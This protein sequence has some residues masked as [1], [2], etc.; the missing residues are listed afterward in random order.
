MQLFHLPAGPLCLCAVLL[1]SSTAG[2]AQSQATPSQI[3]P[4]TLP[5]ELPAEPATDYFPLATPIEAAPNAP[6][7]DFHGKVDYFIK[8]VSSPEPVARI[9]LMSGFKSLGGASRRSY[10]ENFA[11]RY[12]EHLTKR[13]VQFGIG[14]LRGEDPRFHRSGQEGFWARTGFVLSRTV[15]TDM[16]NGGTSIAAGRLTGTFVGNT[17]ANYWTPNRPDPIA[18]GLQNAG[19]SLAG[20][21]GI[22]MVREFWPDIKRV[23]RR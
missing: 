7:L 1:L 3:M 23:F 16:D 14:A 4:G 17:L 9:A 6:P 11:S 18:N 12:A 5:S 8:S 15:L 20:D 21:L 10:A 13:T 19:V 22:R 2:F